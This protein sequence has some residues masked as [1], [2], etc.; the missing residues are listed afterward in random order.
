VLVPQ[1]TPFEVI[2]P[3]PSPAMNPPD[4]ADVEL[5]DETGAVITDA[6]RMAFVSK[7]I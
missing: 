2:E 4:T 3:P 1:H 5:I 7:V 6:P